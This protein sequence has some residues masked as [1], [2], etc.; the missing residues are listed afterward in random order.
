M[1][2]PGLSLQLVQMSR[3]VTCGLAQAPPSPG[4]AFLFVPRFSITI[5]DDPPWGTRMF[6]AYQA[7]HPKRGSDGHG[8]ERVGVWYCICKTHYFFAKFSSP[9]P[10]LC[11]YDFC[12][13]FFFLGWKGGK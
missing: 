12:I 7:H 10:L 9:P 13:L 2:E 3:F 1:G 5:R 6:V 8:R 4:L 11:S